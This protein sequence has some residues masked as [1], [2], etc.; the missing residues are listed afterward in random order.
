[1]SLRSTWWLAVVVVSSCGPGVD[2]APWI[3]GVQ[4]DELTQVTGF[5][6]NPGNLSLY[7]YVPTS[8]PAKPALV[9]AL[10]GCTQSAAAYAT[11]GWNALADQYGFVVAYPQTIANN[12]CFAWFDS[13]E[14]SR[15]GPQ[16]TSITQMVQYLEAH[17]NVDPARVY[18]TGLSAGAA[19]ANVLLA[20]SSDV[21][22]RG[23]VMA[24]LPFACA[25]SQLDAFGCMN[26]PPTKTP[27]QWGALV[28]AVS[29][30]RPAPR[31][32]LWH[33]T[34]DSTVQYG[35]LQNELQQWT[36]V[37]GLGQTATAS[38]TVGTATRKQYANASGDVLVETWSVANMGHGTPV[39]PAHGCGT[40]GAYNLD[41]GLCSSR[42]AAEFFGLDSVPDAGSPGVDAGPA[43][44]DAGTPAVDAG[45]QPDAGTS[46]AGMSAA[47]VDAGSVRPP[48][49]A[50]PTGC[51]CAHVPGAS[52]LVLAL[53]GWALRRRRR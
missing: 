2:E 52:P 23:A 29:G 38:T 3:V 12:S 22:S 21:F 17:Q 26:S 46:D 34:I 24:G 33:G 40:V 16:V 42:W 20:T 35:N 19:M 18:V 5:G 28:R 8:L 43:P 14:Q 1:M 39:D 48:D 50:P 44:V 6:S 9:V 15:S 11:A 47:A 49:S 37:N 31:V 10:H 51:G 25:T 36:N 53:A 41:V 27:A 32:S 13:A 7:T 30:S 4:R 45:S